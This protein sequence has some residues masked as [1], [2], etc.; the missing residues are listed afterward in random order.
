MYMNR[1]D[2]LEELEA[3]ITSEI[4]KIPTSMLKRVSQNCLRWCRACLSAQGGQFEHLL[5]GFGVL[6]VYLYKFRILQNFLNKSIEMGCVLIGSPVYRWYINILTQFRW[7][8]LTY[9]TFTQCNIYRRFS[10]IISKMLLHST[11]Y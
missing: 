8:Y 4:E 10:S 1:P 9:W 5:W 3:N 11:W 2:D 6:F 7:S